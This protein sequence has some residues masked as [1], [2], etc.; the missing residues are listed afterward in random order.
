MKKV[1]VFLIVGVILFG[2][3]SA[4]NANAQS[5]NITQKIIGTWVSQT[6]ETWIFNAN[7]KLTITVKDDNSEFKFSVA[8]MQ[9][10]SCLNED[11]GTSAARDSTWIDNISISSDG[12]TLIL[13]P[14]NE[15]R[16]T[17][18]WLTKK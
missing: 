16:R 2:A 11:Y 7:G 15:S 3:C 4:Q 1:L 14:V 18:V 12:K 6:G 9:L 8:D 17:S 13:T 5:A 10:A